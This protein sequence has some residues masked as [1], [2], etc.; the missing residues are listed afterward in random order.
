MKP[1]REAEVAI[2]KS[3][4]VGF[5]PRWAALPAETRIG[6][7]VA[8]LN[9]LA[10]DPFM[11][12]L[13]TQGLPRDQPVTRPGPVATDLFPELFALDGAQIADPAQ[14]KA[15]RRRLGCGAAQARAGSGCRRNVASRRPA[16][17]PNGPR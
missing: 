10:T 5:V 4:G 17:P 1:V 13:I 11:Y 7:V 14:M 12:N 9:D 16:P 2:W 6:A 8:S 3:G 15:R